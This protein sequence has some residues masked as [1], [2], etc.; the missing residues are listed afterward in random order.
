M[1]REEVLPMPV[2]MGLHVD[3]L[4]G[5]DALHALMRLLVLIALFVMHEALDLRMMAWC[6]SRRLSKVSG[7]AGGLPHLTS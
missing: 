7:R 2:P 6:V 3:D 1:S 4:T 5:V